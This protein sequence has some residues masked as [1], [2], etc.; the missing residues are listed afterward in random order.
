MLKLRKPS[1]HVVAV[2]PEDS[3][4][5][6]GGKPGPHKIQGIGA[7]FIPDILD[8]SVIDEV[9]TVSNQSAIDTSR[10]LARQEGIP[11]GISSGAAVA[12]ALTLGGRAE[13][14][15]KNIVVIVPDFAERYLST[16]L[17]E[18]I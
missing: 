8:R 7:G 5:L 6:S 14:A 15:G 17:F 1:L 10:A 16:A 12:A 4:V 9:I 2:E 11:C 13:F 3:P 18:A